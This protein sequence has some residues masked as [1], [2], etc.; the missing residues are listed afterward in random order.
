MAMKGRA[1]LKTTWAFQERPVA[2]SKLNT[3]D[4]RIEGAL[5]LAFR[6]LSLA[7]GGGDGVIRNAT[8]H[9]LMVE[10]LATPGMSVCVNT[11]HAFVSK[12]P[13]CLGTAVETPAFTAPVAHPRLD[14]VQARLDTWGVSVVVGSEAAEPEAPSAEADCIPLAAVYLRPGMTCITN[15]DD[16]ANGYIIDERDFL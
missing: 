15:E 13:Y 4:D 2:S 7:W 8:A 11:G 9:D 1:Y 6:L 3:W 5:E 16:G 14:L 10:A 12:A